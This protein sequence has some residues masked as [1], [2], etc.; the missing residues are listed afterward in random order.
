M[1]NRLLATRFNSR[2]VQAVM[3]SYDAD[4]ISSL[5]FLCQMCEEFPDL[6]IPAT[7]PEHPDNAYTINIYDAAFL[8]LS[9]FISSSSPSVQLAVLK[10]ASTLAGNVSP[11]VL[12]S[13][14]YRP[15]R[16]CLA[17]PSV[18]FNL[19]FKPWDREDPLNITDLGVN[20]SIEN[21]ENYEEAQLISQLADLGENEL[22]TAPEQIPSF[23]GVDSTAIGKCSKE[24][25]RA[26]GEARIAHVQTRT[27]FGYTA[28]DS[29]S[30]GVGHIDMSCSD[31]GC[32]AGV[33]HRSATVGLWACVICDV[34]VEV[35]K[36]AFDGLMT[37]FVKNPSNLAPF[38]LLVN[39]FSCE[40]EPD[41]KI[42]IL[43][44]IH[45][46]W[47]LCFKV[48]TQYPALANPILMATWASNES[49]RLTAKALAKLHYQDIQLFD[50]DLIHGTPAKSDDGEYYLS[51]VVEN[52]EWYSL[53]HYDTPVVPYYK[54]TR[55]QFT[56]D[57]IELTVGV[58]YNMS[59]FF[60]NGETCD[61]T[62]PQDLLLYKVYHVTKFTSK[63]LD[64]TFE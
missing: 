12:D 8:Y 19:N 36:Q 33:L 54:L 21:P 20:Y 41:N 15:P 28:E 40:R 38:E 4:R 61:C 13:A 43:T 51:E 45:Y 11:G 47:D 55:H 16:H 34:N 26:A 31:T 48:F 9:Y 27:P 59:T 23:E 49:L 52:T 62:P 6:E 58:P 64:I 1:K 50:Q 57:P 14:F 56:K 42:F 29:Y 7:L 44:F 30:K 18:F 17:L 24:A 32:N 10:F 25:Q 35:R 2:F 63:T 37:A 3:T 39:H 53:F 60:I 5:H 46:Q 22:G